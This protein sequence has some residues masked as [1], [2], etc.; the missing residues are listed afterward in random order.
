MIFK[1]LHT[2]I[3]T[4]TKIKQ[5]NWYK[6]VNIP[7]NSL[8]YLGL[9]SVTEIERNEFNRYLISSLFC[10]NCETGGRS[11]KKRHEVI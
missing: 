3:A 9:Y 4:N 1:Y 5:F 11:A 8:T 6:S 10:Q 2:F 7:L